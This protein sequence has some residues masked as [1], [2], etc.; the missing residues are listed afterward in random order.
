MRAFLKPRQ[1]LLEMLQA[2]AVFGVALLFYFLP[3]LLTGKV[4]VNQN[5]GGAPAALVN[6]NEMTYELQPSLFAQI[7]M[8][9]NGVYPLWNPYSH[10]GSPH[11]GKMQNGVFAPYHLPLYVLPVSWIPQLFMVVVALKIF[12]AFF[13]SYLYARSLELDQPAG[14][15]AGLVFAFSPILYGGLFS[16]SGTAFCFPLL[17]LLVE[18]YWKGERALAAL[19]WPWAVALPFC[20]GH[21]ESASYANLVA[22]AYFLIRWRRARGRARDLAA[23][24]GL[25]AVGALIAAAQ[26]APAWEYVRHSLNQVF[27]DPA[28]FR[29][30]FSAS[31][32]LSWQDAPTLAAGWAC[33]LAFAILL[34]RGTPALW[35]PAAALLALALAFL[36]GVGLEDPLSALPRLGFGT[37]HWLVGLLLA[38]L[39]FS[40]WGRG[41]ESP[42]LRAL[43]W[44]AV[45]SLA[46]ILR[47]PPIPNILMHLPLFG[48]FHND[49]YRWEYQLALAIL[50]AAALERAVARASLSWR[51][52]LPEALRAAAVVAALV[53]GFSAAQPLK[54]R[55]ALWLPTSVIGSGPAGIIGPERLSTFRSSVSIAGWMPAALPV[56]SI[57]LDVQEG[58]GTIASYPIAVAAASGARRFF[59][60]RVSLPDAGPYTTTARLALLDGTIITRAGPRIEAR[61]DGPGLLVV[62][63]AL[64]LPLLFLASTSLTRFLW[65]IL[66]LICVTLQNSDAVPAG[67]V[68]YRLPGIE[69]IRKDPQLSRV[70]SLQHNFLAGDYSTIY[71]LYEFRPWSDNLGVLPMYYFFNLSSRFWGNV[72]DSADLDVGLRLLG[73][74]NV[75][76]LLFFPGTAPPHPALLADYDGDDMSVRSNSHFMPRAAFFSDYVVVP[77]PGW[78]WGHKEEL[79][80]PLVRLLREGRLDVSKTLVL[81]DRPTVQPATSSTGASA[82]SSVRV[83]SYSPEEVRLE[84]MAAKPGLVFLSDNAFPGWTAS[85]NGR[86]A[87]ILR[88]WLTFRAVQVPAGSSVVVFRYRPLGLWLATG[89]GASTAL[90]W[91]G[92]WVKRRTRPLSPW[93][94]AAESL[95]MGLVGASLVF[96]LGWGLFVCRGGIQSLWSRPGLVLTSGP[97]AGPSP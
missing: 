47:L 38:F 28:W 80:G 11:I 95:T 19:L 68:P 42:G 63:G 87:P 61:K 66:L 9:K 59:R 30:W 93:A 77:I 37:E 52:R 7:K 43:R 64:G 67:Q 41:D 8:L 92:L 86:R 16:W 48:N 44:I 62:L 49:A 14:I 65:V 12:L 90:L 57:R 70:C 96:W 32:E 22:G 84:A 1:P 3:P 82:A 21:F 78:G 6:M 36:A 18:L 60:T 76:H 39:A 50:S 97:S 20:A 17:L 71:G 56:S 69:A 74:A 88:S 83:A 91:A 81:N 10:G 24:A 51:S 2:C 45:A 4:G 34:R 89:L 85:V 13:C 73:L 33:L 72:K 25:F 26:I 75:K 94:A 27:H 79:I 5:G 53:V 55:A 15:S 31:K 58:R 29:W 35:A 23:L 46:L 40:G 54:A